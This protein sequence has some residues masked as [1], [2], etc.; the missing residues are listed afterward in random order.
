VFTEFALMIRKGIGVFQDYYQSTL[1]KN[2]TASDISWIGSLELFIMLAGGLIVGRLY[3]I[4]GPRP[5]ILVG[6][7]FHI[8]GLMMAS[9]STSYYQLILSQGICS[10]IGICCL[11][12][13]ATNCAIS[14]FLKKRAFAVG[15]VAAG[16]GLGGVILPIMVN[17]L[18]P[19]VGFG[20]AMRIVA[21]L[22]LGL[23]VLANLTVR[24]RIPPRP[25]PL[26]A[27]KFFSPL[28]EK[29]FVLLIA[30]SFVYYLGLFLPIN[31]I[32]FQAVQY[33]MNPSLAIYIIPILN[34]GRY[35]S[36][37]PFLRTE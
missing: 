11:F 24:S 6:T 30:A 31:Y 29:T 16:S 12:S 7:F 33:G 8:F 20:W 37:S 3:D 18:I 36:T 22:Q 13:P 1:L 5:L 34:I 19:K 26:N 25:L 21:F 2:Y 27:K 28:T 17:K 23:L 10:P 4:V 32:Q 14:W 15:I 35:N 9:L